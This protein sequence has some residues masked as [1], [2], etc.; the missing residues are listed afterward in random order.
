MDVG[1]NCLAVK[2][3][4]LLNKIHIAL[5]FSCK[6]RNKEL[7]VVRNDGVVVILIKGMLSQCLKYVLL[8]HQ[9]LF[10]VDYDLLASYVKKF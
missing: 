6:S 1:K 2:S 8:S 3:L 4:A 5:S 7:V 9:N 10:G